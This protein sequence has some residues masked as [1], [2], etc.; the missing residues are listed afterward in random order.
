MFLMETG[1][2]V[3]GFVFL[4]FCVNYFV[5]SLSV[6]HSLFDAVVVQINSTVLE[7]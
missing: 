1:D 3:L 2:Q 5:H 4:T 7:L 6:Y